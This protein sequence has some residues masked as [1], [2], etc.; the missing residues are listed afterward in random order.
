MTN[1]FVFEYPGRVNPIHHVRKTILGLSQSELANIAGVS[2]GT[3][4]KWENGELEPSRDEMQRIRD[5]ARLRDVAWDDRLFF[6][7]PAASGEAAA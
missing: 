4:S 2:Q 3:V 6:E 7:V 1:I 5:A